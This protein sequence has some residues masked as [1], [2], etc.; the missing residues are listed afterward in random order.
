MAGAALVLP[1][2]Q[3]L[4]GPLALEYRIVHLEV[5]FVGARDRNLDEENG[6]EHDARAHLPAHHLTEALQLLLLLRELLLAS[7]QVRQAHVF[8]ADHGLA[9]VNWCPRAISHALLL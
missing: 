9:P 8:H 1:V 7:V 6:L 5:K 3:L 2:P 4:L